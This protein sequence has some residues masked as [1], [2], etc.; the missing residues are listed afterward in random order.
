MLIVLTREPLSI[1]L[2]SF[3]AISELPRPNR[4]TLAYLIIHLQAVAYNSAINKMDA[5]N[6]SVVSP[7]LPPLQS[8]ADQL[9]SSWNMI[10]S[11][12]GYAGLWQLRIEVAFFSF[13]RVGMRG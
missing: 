1:V 11:L 13:L 9:P 5:D 2:L 6:L 3:Q 12:K 10:S 4:D 8:V 7:L